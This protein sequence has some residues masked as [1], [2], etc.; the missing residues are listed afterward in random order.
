VDTDLTLR[1]LDDERRDMR[2]SQAKAPHA[3]D[4]SEAGAAAHAVV[5]VGEKTV[6]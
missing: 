4:A 2:D 1:S 5:S 3:L 6:H